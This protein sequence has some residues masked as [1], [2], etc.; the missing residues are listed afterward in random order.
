MSLGCV[1]A[2]VLCVD[3]GTTGG[4]EAAARTARYRALDDARGDAPVL[5]A[6]T[7]DDQAETVLLG[8]GPRLGRTVDRGHAAVRPAVVPP[9][10]GRPSR[11]HPRRVR[12]A[13]A[14][15]RGRTR[16]TPIAASPAPGCAPRCCRCSRRCSAAASPRRWPAPRPRC[17]R[18][19]TRST[20]WPRQ[21]LA[22]VGHRRRARH[23][24][25]DGAAGG[26]PAQGDSRLAAGRRRQRADRQA[27]P[28]RGHA[29]HRVARA[30][31]CGGR[32][33]AAQPAADRRAAATGC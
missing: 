22:D 13:G 2:Q 17:A 30:G 15:R 26:G 19:P 27:D 33:A 1:D 11:G 21:A 10:A 7:L 5:L 4:P 8:S 9:A 3:V 6:H 32:V 18:T 28:R 12:R 16:T 20:S 24:P 23:R 29:G 25:A 31:R 14:R